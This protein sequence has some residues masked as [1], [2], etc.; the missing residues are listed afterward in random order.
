[1]PAKPPVQFTSAGVLSFLLAGMRPVPTQIWL[2]CWDSVQKDWM[3]AAL[4]PLA[5]ADALAPDPV[6]STVGAATGNPKAALSH[7][8]AST[9]DLSGWTP[10]LGSTHLT[11]IRSPIAE[12]GRS[13]VLWPDGSIP[14]RC[15]QV[16]LPELVVRR[17]SQTSFTEEVV[18][19]TSFEIAGFGEER[20]GDI[21][22]IAGVS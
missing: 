15:R 2:C 16:R 19:V 13:F 7:S 4:S 8:D 20:K 3:V 6:S 11:S 17:K 14:G 9:T 5:A 18:C 10:R 21:K 12:T 1:M 22:Q